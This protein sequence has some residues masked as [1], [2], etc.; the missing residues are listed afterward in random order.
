MSGDDDLG[1]TML[2]RAIEMAESLGI[3]NG[4]DLNL[5]KLQ[6]SEEM[7]SSIKRTAW[8]LFQVDT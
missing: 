4:P 2:N 1:Y 3:I 6:M 7:R 8:G 5:D